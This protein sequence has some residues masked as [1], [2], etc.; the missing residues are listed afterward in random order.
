MQLTDIDR[1]PVEGDYFGRKMEDVPDRTLV[2]YYGQPWL[3]RKYPAVHDYIV[4]NAIA[5]E[6][7]M[8]RPEDRGK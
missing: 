5:L 3:K 6:D 2:W 8:L 4:R 7:I 1:C